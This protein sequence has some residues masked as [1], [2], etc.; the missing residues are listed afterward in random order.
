MKVR[1]SAKA[2]DDLRQI[3]RYLADKNPSAAESLVTDVDSKLELLGRF[4]FMGRERLDLAVG[5]RSVL[6]WSYVIFYTVDGP[7]IVVIRLIDGRMDIDKE[8]QDWPT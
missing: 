4:P 6:V 2:K 5:L 3:Y 8:I 7:E 1:I